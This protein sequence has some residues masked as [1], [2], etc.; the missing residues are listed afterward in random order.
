MTIRLRPHH[1]L[2]MLTYVGK[3]YSP[4]FVANY[5][6]IARRIAAGEPI[7]VVAGP[8]DI[9]A[10]LL[11]PEGPTEIHCHDQGVTD[12]DR[13]AARAVAALLETP[14]APGAHLRPDGA[15]IAKLRAGFATGRIRSACRACSWSP[16]CDQ[17]SGEGYPAA[18]IPPRTPPNRPG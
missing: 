12:R 5:D 16:L 18:R 14:I 17:V 2:C 11:R 1:L 13:R 7:V 8:D 6:R 4:A 10:P 9:C 15:M 3:G